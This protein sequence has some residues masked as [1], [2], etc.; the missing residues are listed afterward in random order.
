MRN[1]I[2]LGCAVAFLSTA[3]CTA[4]TF[5]GNEAGDDAGQ[6]DS[7]VHPN[8]GGSDD[9]GSDAPVTVDAA[10]PPGCDGTK[11]P[12]DDTCV[13]NDAYGVFV[14]SS[15]GTAAGNG[16]Q[17][18][19]FAS[20]NAAIVAAKAANRR[21]YA[22]AESYAEHVDFLDGVSVFGYFACD[23]SWA[24]VQ[25]AHAKVVAPTSPA[26]TAAN[27]TAPTRIEA[28]DLVAPDFTTGSQSSIGLLATGSPALTY[29]K[30]TIHAGTG[31]KGADGTD[32]I[33]LTDS[34]TKM[35]APGRSS[36]MDSCNLN[37]NCE[38]NAVASP[39]GGT[40]A[41]SGAPGHEAGP[42]G[43]GG[44]GGKFK[45]T[46]PFGWVATNNMNTSAGSPTVPTTQTAQGGALG[47]LGGSTGAAGTNGANGLTGSNFGSLSAS[48]YTPSDGTNGTDG[49]PGQGGGG[50][51]GDDDLPQR[52]PVNNYAQGAY[53]FGAAGAGGGA[54]GC[55][56]LA[57]SGGKGGGASIAIL[58]AFSPFTLDS[59]VI[60]SSSGGGGGAAGLPSAPTAGGLGGSPAYDITGGGRGGDG[61]L[62]GVSGNGGG[63]PSIGIASQ[64]T[65]PTQLAST[66]KAGPGGGGVGPRTVN[67]ST[68]P[69]SPSGL[70]QDTYAF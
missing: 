2:V 39:A 40:N 59:V 6:G 25:S 69:A 48:G 64:G 70:S 1:R 30:A 44:S 17:A 14:S 22:C 33:Q 67:G 5:V 55:P 56:G 61:G 54:G 37:P 3:G 45:N 32:A 20:L 26:A 57:A 8:S 4:A 21:V 10:P 63:G 58:A 36:A 7:A 65:A 41:C 18:K 49:A 31:G 24:V 68:I 9:A 52:F 19:P 62:A 60:E 51:G 53:A 42:G 13:V 46:A 23:S 29:T 50:S 15:L 35:G 27:I 66:V 47:G 11:L 34:A 12:S 16:T 43:A 38:L 28:V